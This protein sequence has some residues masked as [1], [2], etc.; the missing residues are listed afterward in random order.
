MQKIVAGMMALTAMGAS[1]L[2]DV[3]PVTVVERGGIALLVGFLLTGIWSIIVSPPKPKANKS[4]A[5]EVES[6]ESVEDDEEQEEAA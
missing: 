5:K 3:D 2:A 1:I 6:Q 4:E